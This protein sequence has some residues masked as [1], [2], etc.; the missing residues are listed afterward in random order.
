MR[1]VGT[2]QNQI[3]AKRWKEQRGKGLGSNLEEASALE[4][5]FAVQALGLAPKVLYSIDL[6]VR[7]LWLIG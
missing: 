2:Y 4:S 6:T 3:R 7:L 5:S 1:T